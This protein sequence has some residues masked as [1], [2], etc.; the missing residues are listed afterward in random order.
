MNFYPVSGR[1]SS[2]V[3]KFF[4]LRANFRHFFFAFPIP[5]TTG[6]P[7]SSC[8]PLLYFRHSHAQHEAFLSLPGDSWLALLCFRSTALGK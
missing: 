8:V 5:P 1:M 2:V 7:D 3:P 4:F 6:S